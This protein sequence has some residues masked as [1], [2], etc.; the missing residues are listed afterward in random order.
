MNYFH[1]HLQK[2]ST[3]LCKD[4]SNL[5]NFL[6]DTYKSESGKKKLRPPLVSTYTWHTG[7]FSDTRQIGNYYM[8][9]LTAN[10]TQHHGSNIVQFFKKL[11]NWAKQT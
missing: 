2:E 11:R 10:K 4:F 9:F 6:L 8:V 1:S 3:K 5:R 7:F